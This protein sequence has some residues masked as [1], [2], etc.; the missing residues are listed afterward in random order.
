HSE[1]VQRLFREIE[2]NSKVEFFDTTSLLNVLFPY[3][4][5]THDRLL[6]HIQTLQPE[7]RACILE[8][9]GDIYREF[10]PPKV[11]EALDAYERSLQADPSR[12]GPAIEAAALCEKV[13]DWDKAISWYEKVA[14]LKPEL[15]AAATAK[16]ALCH[17][18]AGREA[19]AE[20]L[21][22]QHKTS[23]DMA[24]AFAAYFEE[25]QDW[26]KAISWHEKVADIDPELRAAALERIGDIYR[27]KFEPPKVQEALDAYERSLQADPSRSGP[28]IEAAV[29]CEKAQDWD[30]AISWH[31]KVAEL[32]PE[33]RAAATA[34]IALCHLKAGREDVAEQLAK[35]HKTSADMAAA[36]AVY[37]EEAQDWDKV[38]TWCE[39]LAEID[40]EQRAAALEKIGD[41]YREKFDPPKVQEALDA[42]ER[43][44][45]ADP[46][47]SGPAIEAAVLCEKAQDWDKAISWYEKVADIDPEHRAAALEKIGD[48]YRDQFDPPKVQ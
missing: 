38:I 47:R 44:L 26:D 23:A 32:K 24:A 25:A 35:Q 42:Y 31:E 39:K 1:K 14:E 9:I 4:K 22:K 43:S 45:Q 34:K 2:V 30:K 17:L 21:A 6:S 13:Q 33:L 28:A 41:I 3:D 16:I 18:K 20:Q 27:E 8:R 11:Q 10:D 46:S 15:R 5:E 12:S 48:I 36:F 29:L 37:F 7:R 19:V 40:P